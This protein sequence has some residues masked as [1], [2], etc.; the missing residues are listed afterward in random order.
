M[1][2]SRR[3]SLGMLAGATLIGCAP[4]QSD[5]I[6]MAMN[7]IKPLFKP[8]S[9]PQPGDW[10]AEHKEPGQSYRQF[11]ALVHERAVEKYS[12]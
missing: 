6:T 1:T 10:L 8:K 4:A 7:K 12:T 2:I 9:A 5:E 11:R 3:D